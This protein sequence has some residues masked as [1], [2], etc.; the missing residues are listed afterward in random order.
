MYSVINKIICGI[1]LI[2]LLTI[3]MYS[4][5]FAQED[6]SPKDIIIAEIN[7]FFSES[8][9]AGEQLDRNGI[10]KKVDDSM[11]AGFIDN[12]N[13]FHTFE[14]LM[15]EFDE[16]TRGVKSQKMDIVD[17]KITLLSDNVVLVTAAGDFS[18]S[19]DDGR[20]MNGKFAWS[21]VYSKINNEWKI[22][23][24]HMSNPRQ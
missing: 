4:F 17:K 22:V 3:G 2:A 14:L 20:T 23:H 24:T 19:L 9:K 5:V 16:G 18:V 1:P 12:G 11:S 8:I 6:M 10:I 21:F 15:K 7:D 13:Y